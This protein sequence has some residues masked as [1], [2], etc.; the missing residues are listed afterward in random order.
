MLSKN[1]IAKAVESATS[2]FSEALTL[3]LDSAFGELENSH[4]VAPEGKVVKSLD[5]EQRRALFVVLE[6]Q[7]GDTTTDLHQDT[8]TEAEVEKACINYNTH[9]NKANLFHEIDIKE[10]QADQS[11]ISLTEFT[12]DD[13]RLIKKGTW[14]QW[15]TFP[16]GNDVSDALWQAVKSGDITGVSICANAKS[17]RLYK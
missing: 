3:S 13:G 5:V 10:A 17:R 12:T 14:L 9:C 11:F 1:M 6:P 4:K 7:T 15:W 2:K 16:E 8:Y